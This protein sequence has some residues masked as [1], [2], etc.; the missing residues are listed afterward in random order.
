[1]EYWSDRF[2]DFRDTWRGDSQAT[3][4]NYFIQ[5]EWIAMSY[6]VVH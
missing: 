5:I 3:E 2:N 1:M 4:E 6:K